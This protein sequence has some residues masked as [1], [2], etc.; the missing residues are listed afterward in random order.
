MVK[1]LINAFKHPIDSFRAIKSIFLGRFLA[2]WWKCTF[3]RVHVGKDFRTEHWVSIKG[4]GTVIFGDNIR[5][6]MPITPWTYHKDA[7]INIGGETFLNGTRFACAKEINIGKKCI[8]ADVRL[9]DTDFHNTDPNNR[10]LTPEPK[11][12]IIND[13]VWLTI[14]VVVLKGS[15]IGTGSTITPNSVVTGVVPDY[16]L[17]GG[18]PSRLIKS[19]Q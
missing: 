8:L 1:K 13:N 2:L 7:V 12:I 10:H 4:P 5:I 18:N 19:L 6:G 17:W 3:K 15:I 9:M 11:S 16:S 14:Q